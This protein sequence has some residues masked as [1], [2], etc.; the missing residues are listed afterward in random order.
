MPAEPLRWEEMGPADKVAIKA[1]CEDSLIGFT[2][3]FFQL[4]QGQRFRRNWHHGF[5][6]DL[7]EDV[8]FGYYPRLII[9]CPPGATKTEIVSIHWPAWCIIQSLQTKQSTRWFPISYSADLVEENSARVKEIVDSEPFQELWPMDLAVDTKSKSNWRFND[10]NGNTHRMYGASL[11]GQVTGRRAGYMLEAEEETGDVAFTGALILD[12]PLP[13]REEGFGKKIEK[14]NNA[15]NKVVRSRLAADSVPIVMIQQRIAKN[16]TTAFMMSEKAPDEY[17]RFKV[18]AVIDEGYASTL[19][20]TLQQEMVEHTGFDGTPCSYWEDKEP[21]QTLNA[22][23]TADPYLFYSQ[24]QQEPDDAFL[25]GVI[26]RR[27]IDMLI[28]DG[29]LRTIPI[30]PRLPT[31][32]FWDIGIDDYMALWV[33]QPYRNELRMIGCFGDRDQGLEHYIN[34]LLDFKDKYHIR[35]T[36]HYGPHDLAVRDAFTA[37]SRQKTAAQMGIK[38]KKIDRVK[39]KHIS[40]NALRQLFTRIVIDPDKCAKGWE[41]I[42]KYRRQWDADNEVFSDNPVKDWTTDYADALQQMGL[43]WKDAVEK[44]HSIKTFTPADAGMGY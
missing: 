20:P 40:I 30:E 3:V 7:L 23:K 22:F 1:I 11:L 18:P 28:S 5:F 6:S 36:A 44:D 29:R 26:F 24:Y 32:T 33:M 15:I 10:Q 43:G 17:V 12:D 14:M 13:P 41:A 21:M 34:W 19:A 39:R 2:R 16:D 42:K 27:E 4:L 35:Y 25:E 38:F 9:N 37:R 31:F 8:Y